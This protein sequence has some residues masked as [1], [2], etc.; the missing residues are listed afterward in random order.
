MG[1]NILPPVAA[2]YRRERDEARQL[3]FD[4]DAARGDRARLTEVA[5]RMDE[6]VRRWRRATDGD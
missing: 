2:Q 4:I 5:W 6:H 3:V 1:R